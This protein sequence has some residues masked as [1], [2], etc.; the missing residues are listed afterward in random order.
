MNLSLRRPTGRTVGAVLASCLTTVLLVACSS[1]PGDGD[2]ADQNGSGGPGGSGFEPVTISHALGEASITS[3]PERVVTLGQGSAETAIALGVTPV[4]TERYDWGAD[5]SGQLPWIREAVEE[6]GDELPELI[7][8]GE[9][10]SA[11][12]IAALDPDLVLAPWSGMSQEQYDQISAVA[13]TVAY[14]EHP[15]TIDW[16]DQITTVATALGKPDQA[17]GLIDGIDR[18]FATARE[19]NPD[20]ADHDFAFI[21]NQGPAQDMGVF[22]PTEQRAAMVANLGF[23][24]APV[25]EE[26]KAD[27]VVG[28]D[29]AQFSIEDADRLDDVDV[30]FTFY[31]DETNRR[32][33]HALPVYGG[34]SAIR[35]GAEVAPTDQSFVTASSM[36]N[37][38]TVPWTLERYIPMIR[39]ALA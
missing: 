35:E 6:R 14:P 32:E 38:L 34:I 3:A 26:L 10:V 4:A 20:F 28:T 1:T 24:V 29:S 37:P 19:D 16:K 30:I 33:M 9:E 18:E 17:R 36:I 5:D 22:L 39:D 15:W 12:E 11:E 25:V 23:Q 7:T 27:E 13:P 31:S 8:G 21:Y 2:A